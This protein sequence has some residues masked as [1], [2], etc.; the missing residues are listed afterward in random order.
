MQPPPAT[1]LAALGL[2]ES[3]LH[4]FAAALQGVVVAGVSVAVISPSPSAPTGKVVTL[5][6]LHLRFACRVAVDGDLPP[7]WEVVTQGKGRMEG[8]ATLNQTLMRGLPSY[9]RVFGGRNHFSASLPLLAFVKSVSLMKPSLD[10]EFTGGGGVMPKL[11]RQGSVEASTRGGSNASLLAQQL[12]GRLTIGGLLRLSAR[13][14]L[15]VIPS[16]EEAL[17]DLDTFAFVALH[18]FSVIRRHLPA[19]SKLFRRIDSLEEIH[20]EVQGMIFPPHLTT[21]LL[22]DVL[23]Q[24]SHYLNM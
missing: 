20:P 12:D 15:A 1:G 17:C 7:I 23:R 19:V 14:R 22:F 11:T 4:A 10:P 5:S 16:A 9:S 8:L 6:L 18:L 2:S 3:A 13:V 21:T 24:W